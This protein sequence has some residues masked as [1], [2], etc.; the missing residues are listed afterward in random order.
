MKIFNAVMPLAVIMGL[1]ACVSVSVGEEASKRQAETRELPSFER[2]VSKGSHDVH[3]RVGEAQS[4]EVTAPGNLLGRM[5]TRVENGEL[6]IFRK[7][8]ASFEFSLGS[9]VRNDV[10]IFI[11]VP[12]LKGFELKG[13]GDVRIRNLDA[14]AFVL[15]HKGSGDIK[16]EGRCRL[17]EITHVGSGELEARGLECVDAKLDTQGSG[18][19]TLN[20]T[21]DLDVRHKGSGDLDIWGEPR[22]SGLRMRGSGDIEVHN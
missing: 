1:G 9:S 4:V 14:N 22:F 5:E 17:L 15:R 3:V 21:G 10:E 12:S 18:D 7:S 2:I 8:G 13:S 20:I 11:T 16:I 19:I 6:R